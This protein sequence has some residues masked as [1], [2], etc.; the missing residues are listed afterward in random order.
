M[1]VHSMGDSALLVEIQDAEAAQGL[2]A[3]LKAEALPGV[4]ELVPGYRSLLIRFDPLEVDV[5]GLERRVAGLTAVLP[6]AIRPRTHELKVRYAGAD[7]ESVADSLGVP[8]EEVVRRHT[9]PTYSVAF[10][11]FVPGF[12]YL[13]GLDPTLRLPRLA[14]PRTQV[15]AGSVAIADEFSAVY[16]AATPGGWHLLGQTDACLFDVA[17]TQPAL[18]APGDR[19]RFR[20]LP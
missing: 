11:G 2:R 1:N 14:T 13:T 15:A 6:P 18:L 5:P 10:L 3:V 9:A 7:L 19:V 4:H 17:H 12:A 16:P 20:A 8:V